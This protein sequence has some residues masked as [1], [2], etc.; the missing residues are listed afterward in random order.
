MKKKQL[1]KLNSSTLEKKS[2]GKIFGGKIAADPITT[3]YSK[4]GWKDDG[5]D[6]DGW[7]YC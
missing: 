6:A 1:K 2:L 3:C 5:P 4:D 7:Q